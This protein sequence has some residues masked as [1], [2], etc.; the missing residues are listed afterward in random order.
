MEQEMQDVLNH[1]QVEGEL[2]GIKPVS[3]GNINH[4]YVVKYREKDQE[5]RYLLQ[6]VNHYVFKNPTQVM[7]NIE[8]VT[9]FLKEKLKEDKKHTTLAFTP[10]KEGK[11][12]YI[13]KEKQYFRLCDFIENSVSY[14]STTDT[15]I[16]KEAGKAFGNFQKLL[17]DFPIEQLHEVIP[18]F[19]NTAKR[20]QQFKEDIQK[21][22]VGR[23]KEVKEEIE[24]IQKRSD[25]MNSIYQL[26]E[27]KKLPIRVTHNDTKLNNVLMKEKTKEYLAVIDLDTIMPGTILF[28]YGDGIRA[29]AASVFEDEKDL[30]KI[31]LDTSLFEAYTDGYLSEMAKE[32]TKSEVENMSFSIPLITLEECMRFLNDYINGDTYFK[33]N[34]PDH[35]L[36]RTR[37]QMKL[38]Q[39]IEEKMPYLTSYIQ[40]TYQ[41]YK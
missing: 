1:F 24:F 15:E 25:C 38:L 39:D 5:K 19:H 16:V 2:I 36:V 37:N 14:N 10:T 28:D 6:E 23:V 17:A 21:D 34:Y 41:K 9:S 13:T 18:G 20:Y 35:N 30:N 33:I 12:L 8:K 29:T 32:L 3:L 11:Y 31:F 40:E 27:Q 26:M 22:A 7:E 4:T